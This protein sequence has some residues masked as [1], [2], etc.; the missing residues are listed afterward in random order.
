MHTSLWKILLITGLI[1]G[2]CAPLDPPADSTTQPTAMSTNPRHPA[3]QPAQIP[4]TREA[5]MIEV[6]YSIYLARIDYRTTVTESGFLRSVR[7]DNKSWGANDITDERTEIRQGQLTRAQMTELLK[8]FEDW[9]SLANTYGGVPDG[10]N[11]EV[12]YRDK[13]VIA[14]SEAPPRMWDVAHK[15]RA[16]GDA[17][18]LV[19]P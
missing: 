17:M 16:L 10:G 8:L 11:I 9:D 3:T 4:A 1:V 6:H 18:P 13:Q 5:A 15:V 14:G 7:I 19:N 12:R 2:G